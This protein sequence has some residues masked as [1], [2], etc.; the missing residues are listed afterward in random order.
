MV[1]DFIAAYPELIAHFIG[2][3]IM[4]FTGVIGLWVRA[5][6]K[7]IEAHITKEE[8][9][10]WPQIEARFNNMEDKFHG[11]QLN[12]STRMSSLEARI[13]NGDIR[14]I[15]SMVRELLSAKS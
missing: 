13:P 9:A 14:E 1:R 4:A 12:L 6:K 7:N 8:G 15:K 11:L 5:M 2:L 3:L 10:V